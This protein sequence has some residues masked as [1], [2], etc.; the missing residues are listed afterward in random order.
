MEE[1]KS[2]NDVIANA[3]TQ[4]AEAKQSSEPV[5][6]VENDQMLDAMVEQLEPHFNEALQK[7]S[8]NELRKLIKIL[9]RFPFANV[10]K[11]TFNQKQKV[12][13]MFG[14]RIMYATMVKRA[15]AELVRAFG[16]AKNEEQTEKTENE[17]T[18]SIGT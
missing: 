17:Q 18:E 13:F 16:E 9:V 5:A 4:L 11:G 3:E 1:N 2:L 14:E 15:K 6:T 10:H 12:A 8:N 7:L